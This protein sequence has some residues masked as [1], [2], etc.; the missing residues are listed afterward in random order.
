MATDDIKVKKEYSVFIE[1]LRGLY[2]NKK[3]NIS[4]VR[5]LLTNK[6]ITPEE[7]EYIITR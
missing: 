4:R 6:R 5:Q 1:T 7:Y 2:I 3:V